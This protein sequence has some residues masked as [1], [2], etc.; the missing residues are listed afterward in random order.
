MA[1]LVISV[2]AASD[3]PLLPGLATPLVG[4]TSGNS[5]N[6]DDPQ[7]TPQ[8]SA[9]PARFWDWLWWQNSTALAEE[10]GATSTPKY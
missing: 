3:L 4:S 6:P 1:L 8:P 2:S 10:P 7:A 9:T 5:N